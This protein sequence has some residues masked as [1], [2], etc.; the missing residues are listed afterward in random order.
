MF[1]S[2]FDSS[3]LNIFHFQSIGETK[4]EKNNFYRKQY[5]AVLSE[6]TLLLEDP[7]QMEL[8]LGYFVFRKMF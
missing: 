3:K 5:F 1:F 4:S 8:S 6:M 2:E 7:E